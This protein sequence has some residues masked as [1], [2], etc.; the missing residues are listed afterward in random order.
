MAQ[1]AKKDLTLLHAL[2]TVFLMF[3][4]AYV[5]PPPGSITPYGMKILGIF[6]GLLYG[7]TASNLIWPTFLGMIALASTGAFTM[8]E[9]F[10]LSFGNET[11]VFLMVLFVF[12]GLVDAVA[13]SNSSP[14]GLSA[15][16]VSM[17]VRGSFLPWSFSV[18][19]WPAVLS[20]CLPHLSFFGAS[21][22]SFPICLAS[23]PMT[24]I[25]R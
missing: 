16:S 14:T 24:N 12:T 21:S 4:F 1:S 11:V 3:G 5:V 9:F 19:L 25:R 7:W 15:A 10:A 18:R 6:I 8:K 2:I 17:A 23:N 13:S 22:I 20:I